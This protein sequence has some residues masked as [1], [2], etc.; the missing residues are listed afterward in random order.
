MTG[1]EIA[2]ASEIV[3]H[4]DTLSC[5]AEELTAIGV[6]NELREATAELKGNMR[7][8]AR[9]KPEIEGREDEIDP[10]NAVTLVANLLKFSPKDRIAVVQ[11]GSAVKRIRST[12]A[13]VRHI[14][15]DH[16]IDAST[17]E[18]ERI[19]LGKAARDANVRNRLAV[20]W[21]APDDGE[22]AELA[23]MPT[24]PKPAAPP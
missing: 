2:E 19:S 11:E 15:I 18:R 1:D 9:F 20:L 16:D 24:K 22:H 6:G 13:L 8:L 4:G 7:R 5:L 12:T 23:E 3:W 10:M 21:T 14:I 17:E